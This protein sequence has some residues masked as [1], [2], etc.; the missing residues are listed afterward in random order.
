MDENTKKPALRMIPY[1]LYVMTAEEK[2]VYPL[3]AAKDLNQL[4]LASSVIEP[5]PGTIAE[6]AIDLHNPLSPHLVKVR[7]DNG[8]VWAE[9]HGQ[10]LRGNNGYMTSYISNPRVR[11]KELTVGKAYDLSI[12]KGE[13]GRGMYLAPWK[14]FSVNIPPGK[15]RITFEA[16]KITNQM[17]RGSVLEEDIEENYSL[18]IND[19]QIIN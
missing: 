9:I 18:Q 11:I 5:K 7:Q 8:L 13:L 17:K 14:S 4:K 2:I 15:Y 1:G 16:D 6:S 10:S 12:L 3:G 19:M